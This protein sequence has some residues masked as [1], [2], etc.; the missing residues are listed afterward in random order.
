[1]GLVGI[2]QIVFAVTA[3]AA[4]AALA[5]AA[6]E[7]LP[8]RALVATA[9]LLGGVALAGWI[10]LG[11]RPKT[12]LAVV[13]AGITLAFL[14][15]LG[16]IRLR[17]LART[18]RR[19]DD[20]LARAQGRLSSLI[21]READER[22]AELERVLA[23]ARADSSSLLAEQE[24]TI[25]EETR[26]GAAERSRIAADEFGQ[27][28]IAAQQQV[29]LRMRAWRDDLDRA[30]RGV[31]DQIA[32]LAQRHKQLISEA[33]ARIV[34]DAERIEAESESQR[35]GLVRLRDELATAMKETVTAGS[36]ELDSYASERRRALHELN[37]RIRRRERQLS[38]QIEREE[39]EAMR[40][41][42]AGFADVERRQVEQL[43][44]ILNRA[45]A[46]FADASTQQFAEAIKSARENAGA[47]LARELD[48]AVQAYARE[49]QN[50]LGE[51][52]AAVG[53]AGAQKL[54]RR[55]SQATEGLERQRAE[56][57]SEL[58][59]RLGQ[60][61]HELRR[62]IDGLVADTEAER[63]VL[64]ARL[65]ELARRIDETLART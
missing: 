24:R 12:S 46:S 17:A 15:T 63:A 16:A 58:E 50:V 2:A 28:L 65:Q 23:R 60:A 13:A 47:R 14:A 33:E 53:D 36:S 61:E 43:E 62:R 34:A 3:I 25:A 1:M 21:A 52:L 5:G 26:A 40:R 48:R 10:V 64:E 19:V 29:E 45:T 35:V 42:Q 41:I 30:Q 18:A 22:H 4:A 37:E 7:R 57:L 11:L 59:G 27:A 55:L 6:T 44:R 49:A 31:S 9:G 20:Q 51:R 54:E 56:A 8:H 39:A 38:E 32:Q